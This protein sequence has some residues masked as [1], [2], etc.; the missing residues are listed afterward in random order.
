MVLSNNEMQKA[1]KLI[2]LNDK[3]IK[4]LKK[5]NRLVVRYK[6]DNGNSII[7]KLFRGKGL[8]TGIKYAVKQAFRI[9]PLQR[10]WYVLNS[11]I[12]DTIK[13]PKPLGFCKIEENNSGYNYGIFVE[14]MGDNEH[15]LNYIK[16]LLKEEKDTELSEFENKIIELTSRMIEKGFVDTD[17][18]LS[19]IDI[20]Q[21]GEL[22]KIDLEHMRKKGFLFINST[23]AKML[24]CLIGSFV[25]AEQP[26]VKYSKLFYEKVKKEINMSEKVYS[27]VRVIIDET[28]N[29]QYRTCGINTKMKWN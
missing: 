12:K 2:F 20:D 9:T 23:N 10:E 5:S 24:A 19:N 15:A 25:F 21:N 26:G 7:I 18:S 17:Q 1:I 14:D 29:E 28:L 13:M 11:V 27:K 8:W 3:S 22:V 6:M 4:I 16:K